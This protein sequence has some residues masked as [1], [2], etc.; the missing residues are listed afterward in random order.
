MIER[1][2]VHRLVPQPLRGISAARLLPW[3]KWNGIRAD[4]RQASGGACSV[5]G[6]M[7]EKGL[8]GDEVWD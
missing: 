1:N 4:A 5:C 6:V 7:S 8:V 3:A 2:L